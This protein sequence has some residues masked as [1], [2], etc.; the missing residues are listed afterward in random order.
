MQTAQNTGKRT[1][2]M[3]VVAMFAAISAALMFIELPMGFLF[4]AAPFLQLDFSGVPVLLGSFL[5]GPVAG[6]VIS[7]IKAAIHL[8][9]SATMGI[10]ELV[11]F[12]IMASFAIVG[13]FIY[14]KNK[15]RKGALI[16]L[17]CG[18]VVIAVMG[19]VTNWFIAL[20][21]YSALFHFNVEN[22]KMFLIAGIVPFNLLKGVAISAVTFLVYK[23]LS[24]WLHRFTG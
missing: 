19:V 4:P 2:K 3:V 10:G 5:Y 14:K 1:K 23:R 20:P 9:V 24:G 15:T 17:I 7:F 21:L 11:D 13:G 12:I 8:S 18:T 16:G 6:I 22:V